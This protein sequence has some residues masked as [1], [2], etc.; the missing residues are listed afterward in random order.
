MEPNSDVRQCYK[1][2]YETVEPMRNC[3]KCG[4]RMLSTRQL[5][6]LG[7]VQ[8]VLGLFL[9]VAMGTITFSLAPMMLAQ[10]GFT[11][12]PEQASIILLLFG[13]VICFGLM[14]VTSGLWQI[15]TGRR[16]KWILYIGFALIFI[17]VMLVFSVN[18]M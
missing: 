13:V 1:C 16:N 3:P 18:K 8:L 10:H 4:R 15:K 9:V 7:W 2:K 5:R 12:T 17:L 6:R 14:S 11:G